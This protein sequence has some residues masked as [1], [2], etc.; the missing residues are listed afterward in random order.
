M[1]GY[2]DGHV[3]Y[4]DEEREAQ[5]DSPL[6]PQGLVSVTAQLHHRS[7]PAVLEN[8]DYNIFTKERKLP[9]AMVTTGNAINDIESAFYHL[10]QFQAILSRV[11]TPLKPAPLEEM[12]RTALNFVRQRAAILSQLEINVNAMKLFWFPET[13]EQLFMGAYNTVRNPRV[14]LVLEGQDELVCAVCQEEMNGEPPRTADELD[15][16]RSA[17]TFVRRCKLNPLLKKK[18]DL[19]ACSC[20]RPTLC[21]RCALDHLLQNAIFDGKSSTRC[22][23]CRGEICLYD[24]QEVRVVSK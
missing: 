10:K 2:G 12:E 22:P 6:I 19:D 24:I 8:W 5:Q 1:Q 9:D 21:L 18:C 4:S 15:Q 23:S 3:Y 17:V 13:A 11:D 20:V 16:R 14:D 7:R